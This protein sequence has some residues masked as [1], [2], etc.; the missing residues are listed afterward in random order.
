MDKRG[1]LVNFSN[2]DPDS[3]EEKKDLARNE[4]FLILK[5]LKFSLWRFY[6]R[7]GGCAPQ[8]DL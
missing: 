4:I 7:V 8:L 1:F 6:V 3:S 2:H 5:I